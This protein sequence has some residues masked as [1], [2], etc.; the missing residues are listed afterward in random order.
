MVT[1][2]VGHHAIDVGV[3]RVP[4]ELIHS[5][6]KRNDQLRP[7][8]VRGRELSNPDPAYIPYFFML[9]EE[10]M[11]VLL[12]KIKI[13]KY[14]NQVEIENEGH[15]AHKLYLIFSGKVNVTNNGDERAY[16]IRESYPNYAEF[17]LLTSELVASSVINMENT[18]YSILKKSEFINWLLSCPDISFGYL[19]ALSD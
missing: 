15:N 19:G 3:S 13:V 10:A 12:R 5:Q 6:S 4:D 18:E 16:R 14:V 11:D 7:F 1:V 2:P 9:S 17:A 8:L